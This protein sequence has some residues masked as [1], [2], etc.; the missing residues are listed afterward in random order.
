MWT[1]DQ[2]AEQLHA[3]GVREG[4]S[5][6]A[7]TS[8][9]AIGP[10]DGGAETLLWAFRR[11]LGESGTLMVP[12]FTPQFTDPAESEGAPESAS[13][14]ESLRDAIPIFDAAITPAAQIA[15][16]IF[17][18]VVRGHSEARRSS[19]P[20]VSFAAIGPEAEYFT[21]DAPFH[22][23]LGTNSPLSHLYDRNGCVVMIGVGHESNTS[24][25]LAEVWADVPYVH[26]SVR[27]KTVQGEW[28]EMLGSAECSDGFTRIE[29]VLRQARILHSGPVG[30]APSKFM[31]VREMV[32]MAVSMLQGAADALLCDDPNCPWC[33]VA[34]K[35]AADST[36][37][38]GQSL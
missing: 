7:H 18:E 4:M 26:R 20:V 28:V 38:A 31:R 30:D 6:L 1:E 36:H 14:V 37:V 27:V 22:Y 35:F 19:H 10:I 17:P 8:M 23:P 12:T 25:H 11:V 29:P 21:E 24:L 9:R 5:V 33:K 32:S 2:L 13:E 15:V 3:L 16:G 34:R